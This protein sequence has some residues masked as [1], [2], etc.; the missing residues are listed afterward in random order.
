MTAHD[1][2]S[3]GSRP[4]VPT[5]LAGILAMIPPSRS[6]FWDPMAITLMGRFWSAPA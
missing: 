2:K 6:A 3:R 4:V 1:V 5:A